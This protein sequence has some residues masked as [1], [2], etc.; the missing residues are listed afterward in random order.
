MLGVATPSQQGPGKG[1]EG[2][3]L[4]DIFV[5]RQVGDSLVAGPCL[6]GC[7]CVDCAERDGL[8]LFAA[9]GSVVVTHIITSGAVVF[10][11]AGQ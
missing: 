9:L 7:D 8:E 4:R 6:D 1:R 10:L 5:A 2:I 11:L 3:D